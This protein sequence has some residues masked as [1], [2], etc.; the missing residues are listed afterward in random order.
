MFIDDSP[1]FPMTFV[2]QF[3]FEG[4]LNVDIFQDAVD[5]A[6]QR[7]P[8]LRSV[9]RPAKGS[10]DCWVLAD[11]YNS[12]IDF[13][14]YD[15]PI[16]VDGSSEY[17]DLRN[18]IGFKG[19]IRHDENRTRFVALFHH[20]SVDGIGAYHFLNDVFWFYAEHFGNQQGELREYEVFDLR[21]RMRACAGNI[22]PA[23]TL[24]PDFNRFNAQPILPNRPE[25][26]ALGTSNEFPQFHSHVF[27][28][29]EHRE[30]RLKAQ[31]H[32]QT[33]NDRLLQSLMISMMTWNEERGGDVDSLPFCVLM[34]L[35]L[36][37]AEQANLSAANVVTSSFLRRTASQIRDRDS[38]KASL[39]NET[40]HLKHTRHESEFMKQLFSSP[41][42]WG[43]AAQLY[44]EDLCHTSAIFSNAGDPTKRFL[45]RFPKS[46]DRFQCGNLLL[47]EMNGASPLRNMTRAAFNSFTYRRKLKI[48]IR[49]DPQFFTYDDGQALL[50]HFVA[51]FLSDL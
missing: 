37:T 40:M 2:F 12:K 20:S 8:M 29:D 25:S 47:E 45:N 19:W 6:L 5:Q 48:G 38:L 24:T 16:L 51:T 34:P 14:L 15:T 1:R 49:C 13:A 23:D 9:I 22:R 30:L 32:G 36:R 46:G 7:H 35:D 50:S 21:T 18:E 42:R 33:L 39:L 17:I 28:K 27:D 43:D 10:R 3:D 31:D 26:E 44:D 41:I 11:S 4:D